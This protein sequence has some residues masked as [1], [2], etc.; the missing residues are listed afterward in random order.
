MEKDELLMPSSR[1][2]VFGCSQKSDINTGISVHKSPENKEGSDKWKK[3]VRLHRA[4]F[5]PN[6]RFAICSDHFDDS[7]FSRAIHVEG[8]PRRLIPGAVPTIWTRQSSQEVTS[9]RSR[10]QVSRQVSNLLR[11]RAVSP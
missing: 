1:C 9:A 7:C 11:S 6:G 2:V 10:R 4:N 8:R 3:F 5:N